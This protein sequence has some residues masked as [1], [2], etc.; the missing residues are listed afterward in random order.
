[1]TYAKVIAMRAVHLLVVLLG[2]SFL[3]YLLLDLLPGDTAEVLVAS[4][5]NPTP[6]A[7]EEIRKELGL[8]QPFM[9]RYVQW[10]GNA[11]TGDL[12][13]SF[14]T[15]QPVTEAIGERLPVTIQ[16][17]IMAEIISLAIAV[18]L[19]VAAARRRD[20]AFD[21]VVSVFT[22]TLQSIPNFVVSLVLIVIF[23]VTLNWLP[24]IGFVP[25]QEDVLGNIRSLLIPS[26]ALASALVPLYMRVLRNEMIRTLQ[27]DYILVA[28]SVGLTQRSVLFRYAL[29]PSLPTLVTVVGIN[30]GTLIGGTLLIELIS[31]LPGIGTLIYSGI[32]NRDYVLVQGLILFIACAYVLANFIV[33]MIY[34]LLDPRVRV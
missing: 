4:S 14:R 30:I 10:L 25:L 16:L 6:G 20:Q 22:F 24:A 9:V 31:G 2:V 21:R 29:K 1:M 28:R 8:D 18:P 26:I 7:V 3:V 11:I 17:L 33:D 12:G 32:N 34:P 27:E 15:G 19:A 5:S 23:A 13:V